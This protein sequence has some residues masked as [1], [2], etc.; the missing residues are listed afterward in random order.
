MPWNPSQPFNALPPLPPQSDIETRAVLKRCVSA[1][2]A[3]AQLNESSDHLPNP[4]LL[5]QIIPVL[6]AQASSEIENIVTTTDRLFKSSF[7][8]DH[9]LDPATKE[10]ASYQ[11]ALYQ[12]LIQMQRKPL[13][14]AIAHEVCSVIKGQRME[15]RRVPGTVL[16]N[17]QLGEDIYTPPVGESLLRDKLSNWEAFIHDYGDLDPLVAMAVAH[18]QFEA[19]HPFTDGNGRTGRILNLLFLVHTKLLK[20]PILYHSGEIVRRKQAYYDGL[21]AVS[22]SQH[23]ES[24][25]LL[26]LE[27]VEASAMIT[28]QKVSQIRSLQRRVKHKIRDELPRIYSAELMDVLFHQPYCRIGNLVDAGIAKRQTA[29]TYLK[30]LVDAGILSTEKVGREQLFVHNAFLDILR[31]HH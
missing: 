29:S 4:S 6:E 30:Q 7:A 26:M 21:L 1:R 31:P 20:A 9:S 10:A 11:R 2:T 13:C 15:V 25:I 28:T 14:T 16:R 8:Q 3:L 5:T 27:I 24:W 17:E 22:K 12:G 19:I 18:Y 23:W